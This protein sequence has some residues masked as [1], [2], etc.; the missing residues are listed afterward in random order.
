MHSPLQ[1]EE[2]ASV[3]E[4]EA[5]EEREEVAEGK[6]G[7]ET[8]EVGEG[9]GEEMQTDSPEQAPPEIPVAGIA[10]AT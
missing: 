3:V 6:G 7:G 10:I 8:V 4:M 5:S 2:A 9:G 1:Q